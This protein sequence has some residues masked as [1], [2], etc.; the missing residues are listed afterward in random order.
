MITSLL[1][2]KEVSEKLR[3]KPSTI[4]AWA[5]QKLIPCIKLNGVLRFEE[6]EILNWLA[7]SRRSGYTEDAG[8]RPRKGGQR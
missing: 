8:R 3:V 1:T 4:Y 2:V 5:E 6:A 7:S